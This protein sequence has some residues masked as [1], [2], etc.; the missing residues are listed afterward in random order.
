MKI[1]RRLKRGMQNVSLNPTLFYSSTETNS[2]FWSKRSLSNRYKSEKLLNSRSSKRRWSKMKR[3]LFSL[4]LNKQKNKD[5]T[6]NI[7]T[8]AS[9][10]IKKLNKLSYKLKRPQILDPQLINLKIFKNIFEGNRN[11]TNNLG[12]TSTLIDN[13]NYKE[14]IIP[15]TQ[16]KVKSLIF[17]IFLWSLFFSLNNDLILISVTS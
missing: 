1:K 4:S 3:C 7:K 10:T 12:K 13:K 8:K 11:L 2:P 14:I 15:A 17:N 9:L 6:L 16:I 5:F